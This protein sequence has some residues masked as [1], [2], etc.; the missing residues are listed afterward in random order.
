MSI[1]NRTAGKVHTVYYIWK[2]EKKYYNATIDGKNFFDQ[3]IKN[4]LKTPDNS[5]KITTGDYYS[6]RWLH[7]WLF[8]K[9]SLFK[10]YY[11]LIT[12]CLS[13][14][15]KIDADPKAIQQISF[16]GN[17]EKTARIFFI[18]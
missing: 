2:V 10:E 17:P 13:K 14:Q 9:L 6:R 1:E 16:T 8:T 3:P 4:D 11:K 18:I 5:K 15:Q 7:N 12:I